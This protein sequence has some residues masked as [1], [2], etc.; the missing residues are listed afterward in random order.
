VKQP[1]SS[2]T[3]PVVDKEMLKSLGDF[4]MFEIGALTFSQCSQT[5]LYE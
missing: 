1:T 3:S 2:L 4:G 5:L